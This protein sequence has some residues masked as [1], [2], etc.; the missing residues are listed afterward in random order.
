M[1]NRY[2]FLVD[3]AAIGSA[4]LGAFVLHF[5][6]REGMLDTGLKVRTLTLPDIYQDQGSPAEMYEE[7]QL[8]AAN[9]VDA[10]TRLFSDA[11]VSAGDLRA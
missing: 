11:A 9:I 4:V 10:V 7:A 6:S 2:V 8:Q 5:L 1:R 3:L